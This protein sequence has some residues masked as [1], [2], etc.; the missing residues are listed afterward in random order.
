VG[1]LRKSIVG[2]VVASVVLSAA[3]ADLDGLAVS[4]GGTTTNGD[5][6]GPIAEG[7]ADGSTSSSDGSISSGTDGGDG[8]ALPPKVIRC[9]T[10]TTTC[11]GRLSADCCLTVTGTD[12]VAARELGTLAAKCEAAG[13]PN[14]GSYVSVGSDFTMKIPQS[15]ARTVD[16]DM[17]K[18]CCAVPVDT[19]QRL[20]TKLDSIRCVDA[21]KCA[22]RQLCDVT[23]AGDCPAS[24][25]C[26][27][28]TDPVLAHLYPSWC[29]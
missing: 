16:C 14:C 1:I 3:C 19:G 28:E 12:S 26:L 22:G 13:A 2:V 29:R 7:G 8:G 20:S 23:V 6:G 5:G 15:C 10:T 11:D 17:G 4:D 25:N 24:L 21:T 27:P 18:V 9:A